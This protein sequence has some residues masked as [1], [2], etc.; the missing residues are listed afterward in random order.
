MGCLADR[1]DP[2]RA[3]AGRFVVGASARNRLP[4]RPVRIGIDRIALLIQLFVKIA[5][6]PTTSIPDKLVIVSLFLSGIRPTDTR[7]V[8]LGPN[9]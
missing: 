3:G 4:R 1:S 8:A 5:G 7:K 2:S 6:W 9:Y